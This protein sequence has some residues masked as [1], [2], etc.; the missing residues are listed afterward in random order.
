MVL[1]YYLSTP[2]CP[3]KFGGQG[4][5][6][7]QPTLSSCINDRALPAAR[8][9]S[10]LILSYPSLPRPTYHSGFDAPEWSATAI[11][12]LSYVALAEI[13]A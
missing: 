7:D 2:V 12:P 3:P 11:I 1:L 13:Q 10:S 5:C 9:S 6:T 8:P 4:T